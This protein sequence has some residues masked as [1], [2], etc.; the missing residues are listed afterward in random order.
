MISQTLRG[1]KQK[2]LIRIR[3][4]SDKRVVTANAAAGSLEDVVALPWLLH[5]P[6]AAGQP[7]SSAVVTH[8]EHETEQSWRLRLRSRSKFSRPPSPLL[9][10]SVTSTKNP[11]EI[12]L[13]KHRVGVEYPVG[14][15]LLQGGGAGSLPL[16][17][18]GARHYRVC[19]FRQGRTVQGG[20]AQAQSRSAPA[21]HNLKPHQ[22]SF[23][24]ARPLLTLCSRKG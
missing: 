7:H 18:R 9:S 24:T 8:R 20:V 12:P 15:K 23:H 19:S 14:E 22:Q 17:L 21:Q 6:P 1:A 11:L 4:Q 2:C 5:L 16:P 10:Y 13:G 3:E